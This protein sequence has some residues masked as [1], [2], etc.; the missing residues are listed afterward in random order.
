MPVAVFDVP[1]GTKM[2][3]EF[4][5]I[6]APLLPLGDENEDSVNGVNAVTVPLESYV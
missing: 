6:I 4:G 3:W 2:K 5:S 1:S